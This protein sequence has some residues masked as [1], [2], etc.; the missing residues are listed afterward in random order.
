MMYESERDY[1]ACLAVV[2]AFPC[3][4]ACLFVCLLACSVVFL[5]ICCKT[6]MFD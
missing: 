1:C 5:F 3:V 4:F 6:P 2:C